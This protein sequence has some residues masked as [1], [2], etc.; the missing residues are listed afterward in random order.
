MG[1]DSKLSTIQSW[2]KARRSY[3]IFTGQFKRVWAVKYVIDKIKS[4]VKDSGAC[5][6]CKCEFPFD[7]IHRDTFFLYVTINGKKKKDI[8][9]CD[10]HIFSE[11]FRELEHMGLQHNISQLSFPEGYLRVAYINVVELNK[12]ILRN[13]PHVKKKKA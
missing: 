7:A 2:D 3:I 12:D 9:A 13:S 10:S 4:I 1:Q 6:S 5:S 8:E 11:I